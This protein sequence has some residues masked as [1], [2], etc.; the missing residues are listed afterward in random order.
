MSSSRG[1]LLLFRGTD[2]AYPHY[3]HIPLHT[4]SSKRVFLGDTS[5]R[6]QVDLE[7]DQK[8]QKKKKVPLVRTNL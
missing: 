3:Y 2:S 8:V 1:P 7:P 6:V 4:R 5:T